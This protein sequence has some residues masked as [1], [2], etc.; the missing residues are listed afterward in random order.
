MKEKK[1]EFQPFCLSEL[2]NKKRITNSKGESELTGD[3]VFGCSDGTLAVYDV[4]SGS[5]I[6]NTSNIYG[7]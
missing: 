5:R 3:I 7:S 2:R 1:R 4:R 6:K